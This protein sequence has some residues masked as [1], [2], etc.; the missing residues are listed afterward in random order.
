M[1]AEKLTRAR[2]AQIMF[3]MAV[4]LIAFT[5]RT[6]THEDIKSTQE[7]NVSNGKT[8]N[9]LFGNKEVSLIS[10][11]KNTFLMLVK[12]APK[13]MVVY[14]SS[15]NKKKEVIPNK[16]GEYLISF[17]DKNEEKILELLSKDYGQ[18][19]NIIVN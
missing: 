14:I 8:C 11:S 2:L 17:E 16:N 6:F 10:K 4:L 19:K 12:D 9:F 13:D 15:Y 18:T 5:W 7:C 1:A 3:M